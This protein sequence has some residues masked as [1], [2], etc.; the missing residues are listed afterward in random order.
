M[1]EDLCTVIV[2]TKFVQVFT[3]NLTDKLCSRSEPASGFIPLAYVCHYV[4]VWTM[5]NLLSVITVME[6][7]VSWS[8]L[9]E[10]GVGQKRQ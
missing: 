6:P 9:G 10:G 5:K 4:C 3:F 8:L 2:A 7:S 1:Y